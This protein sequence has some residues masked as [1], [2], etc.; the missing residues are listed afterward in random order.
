[1][2][3]CRSEI[4][5]DFVSKCL[6]KEP[7]N[8]PTADG[9]LE[10]KM[11]H[12]LLYLSVFLSVARFYHSIQKRRGHS[13]QTGPAYQGCREKGRESEFQ[14]ISEDANGR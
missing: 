9:A 2:H 14:E 11:V 12:S 7:E 8:R 10:V 3:S 5:H 4:F 13:L 6:Q 1:M